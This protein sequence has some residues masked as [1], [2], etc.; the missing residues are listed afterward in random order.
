M[1][2]NTSIFYPILIR[3]ISLV[4]LKMRI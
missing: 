1:R 2:N 3:F 4:I